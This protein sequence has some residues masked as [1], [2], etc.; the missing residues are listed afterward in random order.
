MMHE[1]YS[2]D[3]PFCKAKK[4]HHKYNI[5]LHVCYEQDNTRYQREWGITSLQC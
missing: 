4:T 1:E 5:K 3:T 2:W